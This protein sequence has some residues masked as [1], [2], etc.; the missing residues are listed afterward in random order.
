MTRQHLIE[1]IMREVY[2]GQPTDDASITNNLVNQYINQGIGVAVKQNYKDAISMDG[3]GY[4][5][6]SFYTTFKGIT[7]SKDE[8]FL[9][10]ITLPQVPLGVGKDEGIANLKLKSSDGKVSIDLIPL[11]TNQKGYAQSMKPIPNKV[12][13]YIEG[14]NAYIL[15]TLLL[16][17]YTASVTLMSGGDST[18]LSSQLNVPDDYIPTVI[19]YV[20]Q[21]LM[22]QRKQPKDA[23]NDGADVA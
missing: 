9:W 10:K 15:S 23:A 7:I 1:Q 8:N 12:L 2:G 6:N 22:A 4:V 13:Y 14:G 17:E 3:I 16:F 18:N 5:N 21:M 11:S 19:S 20:T